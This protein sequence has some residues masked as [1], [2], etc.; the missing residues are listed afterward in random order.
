MT[1]NRVDLDLER[2]GNI[3]WQGRDEKQVMQHKREMEQQAMKEALQAQIDE[4]Q[5]KKDMEKQRMKMEE[6]RDEQRIIQ[7]M[8][9][10]AIA[11]GIDD[12]PEVE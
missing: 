5:R 6:L 3:L 4:K 1:S 2:N 9:N 7:D 12:K 10:M 11:E 8:K